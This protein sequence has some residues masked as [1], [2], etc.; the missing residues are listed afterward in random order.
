L[1]F[2]EFLNQQHLKYLLLELNFY[3]QYHKFQNILKYKV[4]F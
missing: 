3:Q 2:F 4:L 1:E